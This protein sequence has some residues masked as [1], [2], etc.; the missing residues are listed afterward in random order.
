MENG[1]K[2]IL[3]K[4]GQIVYCD[5]TLTWSAYHAALTQNE[6]DPPALIALM[7]LIYEKATTPAMVK[8]GMDTKRLY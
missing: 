4:I 5:D 1:G 2:G 8:H 6:E 3:W 7:P